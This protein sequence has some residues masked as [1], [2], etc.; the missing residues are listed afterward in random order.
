M[1]N[2]ER[3]SSNAESQRINLCGQWPKEGKVGHF[4]GKAEETVTIMAG[5]YINMFV[6][7]N[8]HELAPAFNLVIYRD[9]SRNIPSPNASEIWEKNLDAD[10]KKNA[11]EINHE[12]KLKELTSKI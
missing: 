7:D 10:W 8:P 3:N 9:G 2:E 6:N 11:A 12:E 4:S 5:E 1:Q